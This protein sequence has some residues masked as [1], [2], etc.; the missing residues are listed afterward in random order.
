MGLSGAVQLCSELIHQPVVVHPNGP[1]GQP[2]RLIRYGLQHSRDTGMGGAGIALGGVAA[3]DVQRYQLVEIHART[4]V[5][6]EVRQCL[7]RACL[8]LRYGRPIEG[9]G[10]HSAD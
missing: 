5:M 10:A 1:G 4:P 8:S 6:T 3:A 7:R 2:L 9:K